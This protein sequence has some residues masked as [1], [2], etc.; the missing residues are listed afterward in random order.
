V[1]ASVVG[2]QAVRELL[3]LGQTELVVVDHL[4]AWGLLEG[5]E[6]DVPIQYI[7]HNVETD[8][9]SDQLSYANGS[10]LAWLRLKIERAK[11]RRFELALL[12]RADYVTVI[13]ASDCLS[14]LMRPFLN[15]IQAWPE[16]P[17]PR[18]VDWHPS[19]PSRLLFVGSAAYFPNRDAIEWLVVDF[20]SVLSRLAPN[21]VLHIA[22][23]SAAALKDLPMAS[24]V[25]F[26]G[27]V[28]D[29]RLCELHRTSSLFVCPVVLGSGIKIKVLEASAYG[30]PV[31]ATAESLKGIDYLDGVALKISRDPEAAALA[32]L[33]LL[34]DPPRLAACR[35]QA[36]ESLT[37]SRMS[38]QPLLAQHILPSTRGPSGAQRPSVTAPICQSGTL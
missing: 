14:P 4:N 13:S 6:T 22:G 24:N 10:W 5:I 2:R 36:F 25:V 27:F 38:R 17:E 33:D 3:A 28:P 19:Q 9:L 31:A 7:A 16:L 37:R 35:I 23:T 32:V 15:R 18:M 30:L 20:M 12:S 29:R 34:Y 11:V 26:E 8:V 1:I 21:V